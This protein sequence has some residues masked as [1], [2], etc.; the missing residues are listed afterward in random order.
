M[1]LYQQFPR[2][3][4]AVTPDLLNGLK[5]THSLC[6][7]VSLKFFTPCARRSASAAAN[8]LLA[9]KTLDLCPACVCTPSLW[10]MS[11]LP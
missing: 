5:L 7:A 1:L 10:R 8:Y 2:D 6:T 9:Y 3:S 4:D 11:Q